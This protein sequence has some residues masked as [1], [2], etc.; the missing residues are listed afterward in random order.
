MKMKLLS[1]A[2]VAAICAFALSAVGQSHPSPAATQAW[3]KNYTATNLMQSVAISNAV[4]QVSADAARGMSAV[5]E[6]LRTDES[7]NAVQRAADAFANE[8]A[9]SV[10]NMVDSMIGI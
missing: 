7:T 3:V 9:P 5:M 8:I 2:A 1:V 10:R 4:E 6:I